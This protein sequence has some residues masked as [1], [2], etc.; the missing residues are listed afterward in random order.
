[1]LTT[2]VVSSST[3]TVGFYILV[4]IIPSAFS[5]YFSS[6][7]SLSGSSGGIYIQ[8]ARTSIYGSF[9]NR[10]WRLILAHHCRPYCS[11]IIFNGRVGVSPFGASRIRNCTALRGITILGKCIQ[12]VL[13]HFYF[14]LLATACVVTKTADQTGFLVSLN[15]FPENI[16]ETSGAHVFVLRVLTTQW[17]FLL[18]HRQKTSMIRR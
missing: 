13:L 10:Y 11:G 4:G 8:T 12:E 9:P 1:M 3:Q 7:G 2:T 16:Y 5:G 14:L 6:V 17:K 18:T 15:I